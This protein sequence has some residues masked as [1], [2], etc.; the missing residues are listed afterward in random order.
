MSRKQLTE[1]HHFINDTIFRLKTLVLTGTRIVKNLLNPSIKFKDNNQLINEQI[2]AFSESDLWN[3]FDTQENWILTAG[4]VENLRIA[5]RKINGI[6]I[7]ANEV[8]SFWKHIGNPNIGQGYVI[9]RE[10]REG[11][12]VPTIAGGLCQLSNA[13]YDTALKANFDIIERHKHT[14]VIKGSLAEQDRDATVKWNYIDLRFKSSKDFRIETELSADKLIV[15]F[16]SKQK[17]IKSE[18]SNFNL[19]QSDKL[20]DCYSCGN[21]ACFKHPDRSSV[22]Q[23]IETTTF[24]LDEKWN[25]FDDYVQSISKD[26][27]N[28]IISLKRNTFIRT[29]RYSW[30]AFKSHKINA[31]TRQGIYRALK[32][33]FAPK[34]NNVFELML[35]LDKKIAKAAAHQIPLETTHVVIA[36]NLLPFVYETG[37]LGGRSFDVLMKRLPIEK[38]HERLD[39]AH[40]KHP[41]SPTLNDYRATNKL[42]KIENIALTKARKII[43]PHSE[44]AE[45]FKNKV[46]KLN[47]QIPTTSNAYSKGNKILFPASALGRKGAYEIKRLA[48]EL[49]IDLLISGSAI[50]KDNFWDTI[51]VEKFKGDFNEVGLVIYPTYV[52]HHPRQILKAISKGIP[53][54]TSTACGV[55]DLDKVILVELGNYE[56][57]KNEVIKQLEMKH[58]A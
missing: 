34:Q 49:N 8:F 20:N 32:L 6:E 31:T 25:E 55:D 22:K 26:S 30:K 46:V 47:W 4:K 40:S 15:R 3:P 52:E 48:L 29:E 38:L 43:T 53:I 51:K 9:G 14:K 33:R 7:K 19:K 11:C 50:E 27:D 18:K 44:I 17:N 39:Y 24:I 2:I 5:S 10:I 21:S 54:I 58:Y 41:E 1:K 56:Q 16:K 37:V 42:A 23:E 36:Q 57:L 13:L 12:I 28:F 45:I 35:H